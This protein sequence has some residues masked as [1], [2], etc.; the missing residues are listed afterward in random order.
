MP[1]KKKLTKLDVL[2]EV[3][4]PMLGASSMHN[5]VAQEASKER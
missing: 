4:S 2:H 1:R 3:G 5:S